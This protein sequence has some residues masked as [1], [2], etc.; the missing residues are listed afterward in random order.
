MNR[1]ERKR[2]KRLRKLLNQNVI[3]KYPFSVPVN[4]QAALHVAVNWKNVVLNF[5]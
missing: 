2:S 4:M 3:I 5:Y 1:W